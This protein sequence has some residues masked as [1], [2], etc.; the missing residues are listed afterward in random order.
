[1][2]KVVGVILAIIDK[3]VGF[4]RLVEFAYFEKY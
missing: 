2:V 1:M 3:H 4:V